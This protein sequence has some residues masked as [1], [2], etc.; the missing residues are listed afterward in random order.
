M[1]GDNRDGRS[2]K[3]LAVHILVA[4]FA[5]VIVSANALAQT[6]SIAQA[7]SMASIPPDVMSALTGLCKGCVFADFGGPWNP[8]DVVIT[9]LPGRRLLKAEQ[10]GSRW[11]IQ[12]EHGGRGKHVHTAVFETQSTVH[13]VGGRSCA[14]ADGASC[15]PEDASSEEW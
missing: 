11:I 8:G 1:F 15:S 12:Y 4:Q 5:V 7:S 13:F 3:V 9:G 6:P 2:M 10:S 14:T